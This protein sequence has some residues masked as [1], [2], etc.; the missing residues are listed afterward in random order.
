MLL[1]QNSVYKYSV[2]WK[3]RE[4]VFKNWPNIFYYLLRVSSLRGQQRSAGWN[5]SQD[6]IT[7][8]PSSN[9]ISILYLLPAK[10]K[11]KRNYSLIW[12]KLLGDLSNWISHP[13]YGV[14][15]QISGLS[16]RLTFS[17][18]WIRL[19]NN[20][21]I[22]PNLFPGLGWSCLTHRLYSS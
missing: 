3:K 11:K 9:I 2:Y 15:S 17:E 8:H 21:A 20:M 4:I 12:S 22:L 1:P 10:K 5:S 13:A 18:A 16:T 14:I 19:Y 7:Q 6:P